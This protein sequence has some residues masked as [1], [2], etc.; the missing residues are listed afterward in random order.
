MHYYDYCGFLIN[1]RNFSSSGE[2]RRCYNDDQTINVLSWYEIIFSIGGNIGPGLPVLLSFVN[3]Q[4]GWWKINENN[5]IQVLTAVSV[6]VIFV[7]AWFHV[8]DLSKELDA[9]KVEYG[10]GQEVTSSKLIC[11]NGHADV[12]MKQISHENVKM[13]KQ[14]NE[15]NAPVKS[16]VNLMKWKD[17]L[18]VDIMIMILSFAFLRSTT[19][20]AVVDFTLFST[21]TFHWKLNK[22]AWS[23]VVFG[24]ISYLIIAIVV[25]YDVFKGRKTIFF[26]YIIAMCLA[27]ITLSLF[28]LPKALDITDLTLQVIYGGSVLFL[29]CFI[30]FQAQSSG[31]FLIFSTV[32][33]VNANFVDGF[34]SCVSN[35]LRIVANC[36]MFYFH[37]YP[38]YFAPFIFSFGLTFTM[39][40]MARRQI[41]LGT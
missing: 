9:I 5:V 13:I 30:V 20:I 4:I 27:L 14:G 34:R 37:L 23:H 26:S 11:Q 33:F 36:S 2:F 12:K 28:M 24:S 7:I 41:Y 15:V 31:K 35:L 18:Q 8:I 39:F 40:L 32:P 19:L 17:L 38:E 25:K 22:L 21:K 6:F 16:N 29:K 1:I 10:Q 3:I